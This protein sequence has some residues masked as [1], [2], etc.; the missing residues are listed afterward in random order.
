[1]SHRRVSDWQEMILRLDAV[2]CAGGEFEIGTFRLVRVSLC[3][4]S[5]GVG[6]RPKEEGLYLSV[7]TIV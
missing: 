1:M 5:C 6:G 3:V 7:F 4:Y 2:K